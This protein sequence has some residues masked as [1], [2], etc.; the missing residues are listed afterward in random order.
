[1]DAPATSG[2]P[3]A[4]GCDEDDVFHPAGAQGTRSPSTPRPGGARTS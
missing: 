4:L 1:M 2:K 3:D